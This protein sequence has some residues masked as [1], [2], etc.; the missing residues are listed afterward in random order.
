MGRGSD[1]DLLV[2]SLSLLMVELSLWPEDHQVRRGIRLT[3]HY[4]D[5]ER[6]W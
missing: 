3:R 4:S 1:L 6:P 2:V 5:G